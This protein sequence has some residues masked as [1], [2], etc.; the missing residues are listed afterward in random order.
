[1]HVAARLI[2]KQKARGD[3]TPLLAGPHVGVGRGAASSAGPGVRGGLRF[4]GTR[5]V[6]VPMFAHVGLEEPLP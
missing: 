5:C 1:V 3:L 4:D 6:G 2:Q